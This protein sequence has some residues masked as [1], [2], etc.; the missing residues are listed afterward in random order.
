MSTPTATER[1][2]HF[3]HDIDPTKLPPDVRE[4]ATLCVLDAA[5][6]KKGFHPIPCRR[7]SC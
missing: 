1:L 5:R 7:R 2:V 3:T 6:H 4:P